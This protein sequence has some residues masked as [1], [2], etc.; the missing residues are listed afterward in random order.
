MASKSREVFNFQV[1]SR[2]QLL[3]LLLVDVGEEEV[4]RICLVV[5]S[6]VEDLFEAKINFNVT[7]LLLFGGL[8][9][10]FLLFA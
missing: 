1:L 6:Q 7:I 9:F 8:S 4:V 3:E 2:L 10:V 5:K